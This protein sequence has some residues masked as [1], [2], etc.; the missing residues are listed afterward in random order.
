[1]KTN[2]SFNNISDKNISFNINHNSENVDTINIKFEKRNCSKENIKKIFPK[3][4]IFRIN[5]FIFNVE[6]E[7]QEIYSKYDCIYKEKDNS[8]YLIINERMDYS[9]FT[10]DKLINILDFSNSINIGIIY[11]LINKKN[12]RYKNII[13]DLILVG[14]ESEKVFPN[15]T[16]D[17]NIYKALKMPSKDINQEIKQI[18]FI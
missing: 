11:I 6:K 1:M 16:I 15:F 13:Q 18:D 4:K 10:K 14:F 2:F 5:S 12:K 8:L 3:Q 7:K 17:G 9:K